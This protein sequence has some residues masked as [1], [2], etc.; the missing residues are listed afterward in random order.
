[1]ITTPSG[2]Y[3]RFAA[4]FQYQW[5]KLLDNALKERKIKK[6]EREEICGNFSFGLSMLLDQGKIK[7]T[8]PIVGFKKGNKLLVNDGSFE[9]HE[10]TFGT[11][12]EL[13]SQK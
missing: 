2:Q 12:D 1:M 11:V 7:S 13:Y 6:K 5:M 8:T 3:E 4:E 10:Y 9:Y